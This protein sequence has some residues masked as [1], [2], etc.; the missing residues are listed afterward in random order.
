[1]ATRAT[2]LRFGVVFAAV[3]VVITPLQLIAKQTW[4]SFVWGFVSLLLLVLFCVALSLRVARRAVASHDLELLLSDRVLY[5]NVRGVVAELLRPEVTEI[6]QTRGGIW[7]TS[8]TPRR[9]LFV[10]R[11]F[12]GFSDVKEALRAWKPPRELRGFAA[13]RYAWGAVRREGP[14]DAVLG[15]ALATDASLVAELESVRAASVTARAHPVPVGRRGSRGARVLAL[16][17]LLVIFFL[18]IWQV[19]QPSERTPCGPQCKSTGMCSLVGSSCVANSDENCQR[20]TI[21]ETSGLCKAAAGRCVAGSDA[22]CRRSA[23]CE[24]L[25]NC[26]AGAGTCVALSN[27]DCK[28][29]T[30]CHDQ[31]MCTASAGQCLA[32]TDEDCKKAKACRQ[33][34]CK[35][36]AGACVAE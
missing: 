36:V 30:V 33:R 18:A 13:F 1:V 5:R 29:S 8:S 3:V 24:Y 22:D 7:V 6:V 2:F 11:A 34:A 9:S 17:V 12:D 32:A 27:V 31:G 28:E 10:S 25:G 21:C 26:S 14:R 23:G 20:S 35:A 19:L 16:W 15:T 4:P